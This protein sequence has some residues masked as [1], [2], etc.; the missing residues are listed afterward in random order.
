MSLKTR[1]QLAIAVLMS[2]VVVTLSVLYVRE[3]LEASFDR[4]LKV[5]QSI[6]GQ[7]RAATAQELSE[8]LAASY[9]GTPV[10]VQAAKRFWLE[11]VETDPRIS[12]TLHRALENWKEISEV[13]IT[14]ES[15]RIRISSNPRHIG[16]YAPHAVNFAEWEKR[17]LIGNV[18]QVFFKKQ[19]T[20]FVEPLGVDGVPVIATHVVISSLFLRNYVIWPDLEDVAWVFASALL[21]GL[22]LAVILPNVVLN[23]L[24]RVSQRIDLI[25][26]GKVT[27]EGRPRWRESKEVAALYSKLNLLGEQYQYA[28]QDATEM[29]SNIQH[30]LQKLENAVLL[31]DPDGRLMV[32]GQAV[33]RLLGLDPEAMAGRTVEELFP[34]GD[35]IGAIVAEAAVQRKAIEGREVP[36]MHDGGEPS[37]ILVS[38]E[39]LL[40]DADGK[41]MGVLATLR[42]AETRGQLEAQLDVAERLSAIG[43]LM[44]GVAHEIKNPLNAITLHLEV[45]RSRLDGEV[46]EVTVI[47]SEISRLDRVVK[48]F[49]DF[50]RPVEP[51][52][53][54]L[55]LSELAREI[56]ALVEPD[57]AARKVTVKLEAAPVKVKIHGDRDLLNQ[58]ALNVVMNGIEA[59]NQGGT[60]T[61]STRHSAKTCELCISD[62]GPGIP[63][64]IRDKIFNLYFSTKQHGSGI[65]LAMTFRFVQLHN[66]KIE[67][68]TEAGKGTTF[69]F[70]FPEA[71]STPARQESEASRTHH[72][73]S[74]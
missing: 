54:P 35:P 68:T 46:P 15:G 12:A 45:L 3:F 28:R 59:M 13:Y 5:A 26:K 53:R 32:A 65:G 66:G 40:G 2:T 61:I 23:P 51:R 24:E 52:M 41:L 72:T 56:F 37:R 60:L 74:G 4:T 30:L 18:R 73:A 31:F 19:D 11:T 42:D 43:Q 38:A 64:E 10:G 47:A 8:K 48:T 21:V 39:P 29:R 69:K 57:A 16:S 17:S 27:P 7:V 44:R 36:V 22:T 55:D 25:A 70:L 71:V 9:A 14:D 62:T 33:H 63:P 49:L 20:E 6:T 34:G 50:N 67:F 1:L 58:A